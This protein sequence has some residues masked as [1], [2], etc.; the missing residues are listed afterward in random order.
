MS[1]DGFVPDSSVS[2]GR[3]MYG[4]RGWARQLEIR[5]FFSDA[6]TV[7]LVM[8]T[9]HA[10]RFGWDPLSRVAGSSTPA[11][12]F[13]TVAISALWL[14]QLS[15]SR[16]REARI[17]G[18]G[19]Q[20]FQRVLT[21]SWRTFAVIAIVG[22]LTQWQI[23]RGYLLFA[24]PVGTIALMG[25]RA[26]WRQWM[27]R[28]RD[29]GALQA[30]VIVAGPFR[31]SVE[32]MRRLDRAKR[33]GF[34]V[35]GVCLPPSSSGE[36]PADIAHVPVLG[37][38]HDA[39][40]HATRIGAEFVLIS[41]TDEMSLAESRHISWALEGT[42]V[43]LIV[44]PSLV[45]VAG[46]RVSM[47]PVEGLPLLH[48]EGPRFEGAKYALKSAVDRATAAVMLVVLALPLAVIALAVRVS[49]PGPVIF[50]QVRV[51]LDHRLF[52]MLKF[53]SMYEDADER[54]EAL[55]ESAEGNG[56]LF[57]MKRDPRVTRVGRTIRRWSLDELPQ[58]WNVLVGD[59]ALVGPR[60]PLPSEVEMWNPDEGM[61]RRQMVK[62]GI[63]GL[64]Q[65]SGRS[66]LSWD[67]SVRLDL[68]YTENWSLGGDAVI[69]LRTLMAI[70]T[71]R[72]AY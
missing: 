53:R 30:Q 58:L 72:G 25:T 45:D 31:T 57:K 14:L 11:Y 43:G 1:D 56:V 59:M 52:S 3:R 38:I 39:A 44:A 61:A 60:P 21:A 54:L 48:V 12:W 5:L 42:G 19:T 36:L 67:E 37:S 69:I 47:S 68:Y 9:A 41:G 15:W 40:H 4:S 32:T 66:D 71:R 29:R 16:S 26:L 33:A 27:H 20:E 13:V 24:L 49:S 17:L 50:R 64:W 2:S 46:P 22:F 28:Q 70:I 8:V 63:T 6:V 35:V 55:Q 34:R 7:A 51:G 65:V 18:H 10:V 62:P 23:S